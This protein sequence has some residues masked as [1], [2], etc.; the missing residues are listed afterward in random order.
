M[1]GENAMSETNIRGLRETYLNGILANIEDA[2]RDLTRAK[3][4]VTRIRE[5]LRNRPDAPEGFT[6]DK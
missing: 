4:A 1:R 2:E 6:K 5:E 3:E